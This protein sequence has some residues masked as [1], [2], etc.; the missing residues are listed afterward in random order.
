MGNAEV[1]IWLPPLLTMDAPVLSPMRLNRAPPIGPKISLR[2]LAPR[3]LPATIVW[4]SVHVDGGVIRVIKDG[5]PA[6]QA[7]VIARPRRPHYP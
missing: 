2:V 5:D 6:A 1:P 3:M 4:S 7:G